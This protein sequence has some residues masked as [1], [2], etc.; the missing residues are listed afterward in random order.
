[1][2]K[3]NYLDETLKRLPLFLFLGGVSWYGLNTLFEIKSDVKEMK[4]VV[5]K[6]KESTD[7]KILDLQTLTA[8]TS[9]RTTEI[10]KDIV[11]LLAIMPNRTEVPKIQENE[12]NN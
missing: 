1:M 8:S 11:R 9:N 7:T 5:L 4:A 12:D 3:F 2:T 6:D 10:E